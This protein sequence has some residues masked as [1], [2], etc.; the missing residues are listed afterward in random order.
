M[1]WLATAREPLSVVMTRARGA[2]RPMHGPQVL[3]S[4]LFQLQCAT[5]LH[6]CCAPAPLQ[7]ANM[8]PADV[9]HLFMRVQ[10]FR[11]QPVNK[12]GVVNDCCCVRFHLYSPCDKQ[13]CCKLRR[14]VSLAGSQAGRSVQSAAPTGLTACSQL[15]L[16]TGSKHAASMMLAHRL[17]STQHTQTAHVL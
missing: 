8:R 1:A 17:T 2:V 16:W 15:P 10:Q 9:T 5:V 11:K 7:C 4:T 3:P 12:C 13:L 6:T 14:G